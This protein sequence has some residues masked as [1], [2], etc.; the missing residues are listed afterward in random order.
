VKRFIAILATGF[1]LFTLLVQ[2]LTMKALI[3]ALGLDRLSPRDAA[4]RGQ[5]LAVAL[6]NVRDRIET[7]AELYEVKSPIALAEARR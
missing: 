4:L 7:V 2:G 3:H 1:V 6:Q 5:V